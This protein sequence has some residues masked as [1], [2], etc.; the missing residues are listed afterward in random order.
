MRLQPDLPDHASAQPHLDSNL[1]RSMVPQTDPRPRHWLEPGRS[2]NEVERQPPELRQPVLAEA[3]SFPRSFVPVEEMGPPQPY[4]F[5]KQRESS[6]C[7]G[8]LNWNRSP[9]DCHSNRKQKD[10]N[11]P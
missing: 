2:D 1:R 9:E 6:Q 8:P 7:A 11:Q 10:R 3:Q 4:T 5:Q